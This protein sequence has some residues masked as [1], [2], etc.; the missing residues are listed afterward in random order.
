VNSDALRICPNCLENDVEPQSRA[1]QTF[2]EDH[3]FVLTKKGMMIRFA[4]VQTKETTGRT[5]KGTKVMELR[6][7]KKTKFIDELIFTA[8]LPG[9]LVDQESEITEPLNDE[10][11]EGEDGEE[12]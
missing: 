3:L 5:T 9:E 7:P 10:G 12:E 2:V 11:G 4:A 1:T 6:N 8:R